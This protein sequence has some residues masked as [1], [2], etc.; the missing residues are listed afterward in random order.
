MKKLLH[1]LVVMHIVS[2]NKYFTRS[3]RRQSDNHSHMVVFP[4]PLGPKNPKILP[5]LTLKLRISIILLPLMV[6]EVLH[7]LIAVLFCLIFIIYN[8]LVKISSFALI[9]INKLYLFSHLSA[10]T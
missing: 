5:L 7:I 6:F 10:Q 3:Y 2:V 4:A 9:N 8:T 1:H